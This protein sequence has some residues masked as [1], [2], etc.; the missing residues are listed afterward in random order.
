LTF[1][2]VFSQPISGLYILLAT[3][4]S[5]PRAG[6]LKNDKSFFGFFVKLICAVQLKI[7]EYVAPLEALLSF[8][9]LATNVSPRKA[10]LIK[11]DKSFF[12]FFRKTYL[13]CA[14]QE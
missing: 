11:N 10:G 9:L 2:A 7:R 14:T 3:N 4:V 5:P 12:L 6:L 13:R 1:F 8:L